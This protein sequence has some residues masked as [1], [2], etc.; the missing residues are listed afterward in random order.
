MLGKRPCV[1]PIVEIDKPFATDDRIEEEIL[2]LHLGHSLE[3]HAKWRLG[4]ER[5]L[6]MRAQVALRDL[7]RERKYQRRMRRD[8]PRQRIESATERFDD[9]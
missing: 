3:S 8:D 5:S 1:Q 2:L 7:A 4:F 6:D 9:V